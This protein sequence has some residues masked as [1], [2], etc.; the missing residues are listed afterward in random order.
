MFSLFITKANAASLPG[1]FDWMSLMPIVVIFAIFYLLILRPQQKKIQK[2]QNMISSLKRG[3]KVLTNGGIIGIVHRVVDEYEI[4]LEIADG[5]RV[6]FVRSM[7]TDILP[8]D[9][10]VNYEIPT[11]KKTKKAFAHQK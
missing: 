6:R 8:N 11:T 7:I 9:T 4:I 5:V 10:V 2:Q 3:N 1:G